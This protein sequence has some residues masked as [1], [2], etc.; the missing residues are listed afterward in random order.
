M[1]GSRKWKNNEI[2]RW[3]C[4]LS[5]KEAVTKCESDSGCGGF[6]FK[7]IPSPGSEFEIFFFH[8]ITNISDGGE[9]LEW[10][11]YLVSR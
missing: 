3:K 11:Y 6:T 8:A 2:I 10:T 7:G 1:Y 5:E 4:T 9:Y